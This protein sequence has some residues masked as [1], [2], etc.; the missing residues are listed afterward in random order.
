MKRRHECR[1][2]LTL[3]ESK[4]TER[5]DLFET[6]LTLTVVLMVARHLFPQFHIPNRLE[7]AGQGIGL[8]VLELLVTR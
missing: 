2:L 3:K 1:I 6:F 8:R 4:S 5:A 7:D